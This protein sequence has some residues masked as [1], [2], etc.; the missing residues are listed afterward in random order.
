LD[1]GSR[2]DPRLQQRLVAVLVFLPLALH[3]RISC[4][5]RPSHHR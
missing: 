2:D 5:H 1:A 3:P 4:V